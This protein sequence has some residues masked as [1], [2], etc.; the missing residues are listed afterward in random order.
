MTN[1]DSALATMLRAAAWALGDAAFDVGG[2][3][4][5]AKQCAELVESLE[6]LIQA[7]RVRAQRFEAS[8]TEEPRR[9]IEG[10][11]HG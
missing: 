10:P 8:G 11:S 7:L 1:P 9:E 3:R 5:T 2:G 4:M 6:A